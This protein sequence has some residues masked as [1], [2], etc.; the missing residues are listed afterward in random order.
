ML[1]QRPRTKAKG[2][3]KHIAT[4]TAGTT[5]PIVPAIIIFIK[6]PVR[7]YMIWAGAYAQI[8]LGK[9][10]NPDFAIDVHGTAKGGMILNGLREI[11][12]VPDMVL[13]L[14]VFAA[15]TIVYLAHTRR[16]VQRRHATVYLFAW[17]VLIS[18]VYVYS[19][20]YGGYLGYVNQVVLFLCVLSV[21]FIELMADRVGFKKLLFSS[22]VISCAV[23]LPFTSIIRGA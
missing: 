2:I 6:E 8:Y 9:G 4:F 7:A 11:V 18:I 5:I 13:L 20:L 16:H 10:A 21:P 14:A 17:L 22:V 3:V 19:N 12:S 1:R 15:S 23:V